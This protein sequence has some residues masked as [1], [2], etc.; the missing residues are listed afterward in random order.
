MAPR[1]RVERAM[2]FRRVGNSHVRP[3]GIRILGMKLVGMAGFEPACSCVRGRLDK[4]L[5][6]IPTYGIFSCQRTGDGSRTCPAHYGDVPRI[7]LAPE[8]ADFWGGWRNLNPLSLVHS[9]RLYRIS[10]SHT[11]WISGE[12]NPDLLGAGQA[13]SRYHQR[14][15]LGASAENRTPLVEQ[16][17]R[18]S[19]NEPHPRKNME[20]SPGVKPGIAVWKT[21][22]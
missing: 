21:A 16:A 15:E 12:L 17:T 20:R 18:H 14:P 22:T 5:L 3:T 6:Y 4:P 13:C 2:D 19:T 1:A 7:G 8:R 11:W 9:Q 10:Y